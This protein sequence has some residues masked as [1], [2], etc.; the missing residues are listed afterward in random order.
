MNPAFISQS[1]PYWLECFLEE[2][3]GIPNTEEAD[4]EDLLEWSGF[5]L[6]YIQLT[7]H[8]AGPELWNRIDIPRM[9]GCYDTLHTLSNQVAKEVILQDYSKVNQAKMEVYGKYV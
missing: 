9:M 7:E 6:M 2:C 1:A 8:L 4:L 3:E 5:I